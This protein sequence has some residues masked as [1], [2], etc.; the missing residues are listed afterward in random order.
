MA[1]I[2]DIFGILLLVCMGMMLYFMFFG[3]R[4]SGHMPGCFGMMHGSREQ[5]LEKEVEDLKKEV[6]RLKDGVKV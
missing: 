1:Y 6:H 2:W 5:E 4:N 3:N